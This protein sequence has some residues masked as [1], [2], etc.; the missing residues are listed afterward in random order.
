MGHLEP[1]YLTSLSFHF[2]LCKF[3]VIPASP[4]SHWDRVRMYVE[5]VAQPQSACSGNIDCYYL[6]S[7][8]FHSDYYRA[9]REASGTGSAPQVVWPKPGVLSKCSI[10]DRCCLIIVCCYKALHSLAAPSHHCPPP[11]T[12]PHRG[13]E[14]PS[15]MP[16]SRPRSLRADT[17]LPGNPFGPLSVGHTPIALPPTELLLDP[18]E[19]VSSLS[20]KLLLFSVLTSSV[21]LNS[22]F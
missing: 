16:C 14:F 8:I 17:L 9:T 7:Y 5:Q 22:V 10:I 1:S 11:P 20:P 4:W 18:V 21:A 13:S 15:S 6:N 2:L 19:R 3:W 12:K